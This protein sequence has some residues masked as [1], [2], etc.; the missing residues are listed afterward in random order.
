M[1][2]CWS[3]DPSERPTADELYDLFYDVKRKLYN[4]IVD[5]EVMRQLKIADENQK[6]TSKSQK[7][8]LLELFSYSNLNL[9]LKS[10]ESTT[11]SVNTHNIDEE[12]E[13]QSKQ[14]NDI[15]L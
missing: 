10:N 3:D 1:Y 13:I 4:I 6:N 5:D 11:S 2:R 12:T 7:Q 8:E 14:K 15:Q 9:L